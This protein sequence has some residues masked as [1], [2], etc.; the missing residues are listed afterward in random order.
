MM[1]LY[2]PLDYREVVQGETLRSYES[3]KLR[4]VTTNVSKALL[5]RQTD[6]FTDHE[7][8]EAEKPAET[9]AVRPTSAVVPLRRPLS[10]FQKSKQ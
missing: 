8:P 5:R 4:L 10:S 7:L 6:C 2:T 3:T 9:L 1:K